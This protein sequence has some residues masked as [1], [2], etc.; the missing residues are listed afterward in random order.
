[1]AKFEIDISGRKGLAPQHQGNVVGATPI[2]QYLYLGDAGQMA[3]GTWNPF[4]RY[5]YLQ[6]AN[7]VHTALTGTI[8][9]RIVTDGWD[10]VN[11]DLYLGT[12]G[13]NFLQLNGLDDTSLSNYLTIDS[14]RDI[15]D[16]EPYEV[17]DTRTMAYVT[18]TSDIGD[19]MSVGF[20]G[21]D[22]DSGL[23][24]FDLQV[25]SQNL[26]NTYETIGNSD[27]NEK[28][29]QMIRY[30]TDVDTRYRKCNRIR[31]RLSR[32]GAGT[33]YTIKVGIQKTSDTSSTSPSG[34]YLA[35]GTIDPATIDQIT[36][37]DVNGQDVYV[38]LD[39]TVTFDTTRYWI[40][41]EPTVLGDMVGTNS[42]VWYRSDESASVYSN[43]NAYA[44]A[45]AAW[46]AADTTSE[47]FDCSLI[48]TQTENWFPVKDNGLYEFT[49]LST[50]T[51][52][53]T[54]TNFTEHS[55]RF[56]DTHIIVTWQGSGNDG[57]VQAFS[58]TSAGVIT[59]LGSALEFDITR[60]NDIYLAKVDST[61][62]L[63]VWD[64]SSTAVKAQVFAVDGSYNVTAVGATLSFAAPGAGN[65]YVTAVEMITATKAVITYADAV[66]SDQVMQVLSID[67]A[68]AVTTLGAGLDIDTTYYG[69]STAGLK[70]LTGTYVA[71]VWIGADGDGFTQVFDIDTTTGTIT[72][73]GSPVEIETASGVD[74]QLQVID[75]TH[76][77]VVGAIS[78]AGI[79]LA[80]QVYT[81]DGSYNV[82]ASGTGAILY[83]SY[84]SSPIRM[85]QLKTGTY[86][87]GF[88]QGDT[89]AHKLI[90]FDVD[91][92][93]NISL[94]SSKV[95]AAQAI[96]TA[97]RAD[98]EVMSPTLIVYCYDNS[99][100][101]YITSYS[102]ALVYDDDNFYVEEGQNSFLKMG[103]N[104]LLY[105]FV[106]NIV[107]VIDGS[108][109]GGLTGTINKQA[110][111]FPSYLTIV[112]AVDAQ[113]YMF[114][115]I[116]S[117]LN[118]SG[119]SDIRTFS[120]DPVGVYLW[121]RQTTVVGSRNYVP[122][123]G[124][125]EIKRLFITSQG[126]VMVICI[127]NSNQTEIRKYSGGRFVVVQKLNQDGYPPYRDSLKYSG[128][129]A[130][131]QSN[132]GIVYAYGQPEYTEGDSLFKI[133]DVSSQASVSFTPGILVAGNDLST[134]TPQAAAFLSWADDTTNKFTRWYINGTGTI[135]SV[136]QTG[137]IGNV[138][139]LTFEFPAPTLVEYA[140]LFALP[141]S[142]DG[143][144]N[145]TVVGTVKVY[146]NKKTTVEKTFSITRKDLL[147]G[148]MYL[149]LGRKNATSI[150]F[151]VEFST[152]Q[153]LGSYD[154]NPSRIVLNYNPQVE[155]KK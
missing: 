73:K 42:F 13:P 82:S 143:V 140:H 121:D 144:G 21:L 115:G 154:F 26:D 138:H 67:G 30:G 136:A 19:G 134:G 95:Q 65:V 53:N 120:S 20:F 111:T 122:L 85:R 83:R 18:D 37:G 98:I 68:Y 106:G 60:G 61:H 81:V 97:D 91:S 125:K 135:A 1:M 54:G 55:L 69:I 59:A 148:Y 14:D 31:L 127:N 28:L 23:R 41:V 116:H 146:F 72:A 77:V 107:H 151:E 56:D 114:I 131:W 12:D 34:T 86:V 102:A 132:D 113:G 11:D 38:D 137:H 36:D 49:S 70:L 128:N 88:R 46:S 22:S 7:N 6:P 32:L 119:G 16:M 25:V 39:T 89:S 153:T 108:L 142:D 29:A 100:Q 92:S 130:V 90:T 118:A 74:Y 139:T 123:Y 9:N 44:Y 40:V 84:S 133:G 45:S 33:S 4:Y 155:S 76:Y 43:G 63:M 152:S 147:D 112:D 101:G 129:M 52:N 27:T 126:D 8:S 117:N 15:M 10:S 105:W 50:T 150:S 47:S 149:P 66:Q 124:V 62:F 71:A 35:Y 96:T 110:L 75:S 58:V 5:G 103:D 87:V 141:T 80:A 109:T 24:V 17:S 48:L 99:S 2:P 57:Y 94:V 3:D 51:H 145:S 104:G 78:T 93:Y 64:Q 79:G